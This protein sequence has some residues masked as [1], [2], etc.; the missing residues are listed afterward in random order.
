MGYTTLDVSLHV[1]ALYN[2]GIKFGVE[3]WESACFFFTE[4]T[5]LGVS[6]YG[7]TIR[8]VNSMVRWILIGIN[9]FPMIQ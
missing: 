5:G 8:P 7:I 2:G 3:S 6:L 4:Y 1:T 9:L